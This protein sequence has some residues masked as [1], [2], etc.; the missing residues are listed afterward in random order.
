MKSWFSWLP[1]TLFLAV[2]WLLLADAP[3]SLGTLAFGLLA[4]LII[5]LMSRRLRPFL[6]KPR[7]LWVIVKLTGIVLLDTFR[8]NVVA[9]KLIT[10]YPKASITSG[11]VTVP[12]TLRD[13]HGLAILAAII[14]YAPG[15]LWAGFPESGDYVQLHILDLPQE[16]DWAAFILERY[17]KP[18]K[19]IFE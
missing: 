8:S 2:I 3:L 11:F 1:L 19:E 14:N 10:T 16:S 6:A 7:R 17:E 9:L 18:L 15:T 4:A 13:P 12:L 5:V